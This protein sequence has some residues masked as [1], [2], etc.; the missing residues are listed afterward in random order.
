M[1]N[2]AEEKAAIA[3]ALV[4]MTN[5]MLREPN[6]QQEYLNVCAVIAR[7]DILLSNIGES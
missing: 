1:I 7:Y 5:I 2:I 4:T 6:S 3:D